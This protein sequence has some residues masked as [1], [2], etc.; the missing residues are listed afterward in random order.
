MIQGLFRRTKM[1]LRQVEK[2]VERSDE[3]V[4]ID[5]KMK[6]AQLQRRKYIEYPKWSINHFNFEDELIDGGFVLE[7][8]DD[9]TVKISWE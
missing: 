7:N 9:T 5:N 4:S 1:E 8:I 2:D 6:Q 3:V